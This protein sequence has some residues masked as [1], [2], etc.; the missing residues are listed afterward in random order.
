MK[1][2][3]STDARR[4]LDQIAEYVSRHNPRAAMELD[5]LLSAAPTKLVDFPHSGRP[6]MIAGTREILPH[7]HYRIVYSVTD[8]NIRIVAIVH[9]S[10]QSPPVADEDPS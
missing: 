5:A 4:D 6:G 1:V 8:D 10:R 9:T 3:W 7:K 2:E